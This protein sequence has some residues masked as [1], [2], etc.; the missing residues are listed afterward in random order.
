MNSIYFLVYLFPLLSFLVALLSAVFFPKMKEDTVSKKSIEYAALGFSFF[1]LLA[2]STQLFEVFNTG[3]PLSDSFLWTNTGTREINISIKI[4]SLTAFFQFSIS[5]IVFAVHIY[6]LAY[7]KKKKTFYYGILGLF[8]FAMQF[9]LAQ[10][11]LILFFVFWELMGLASFLLIDFDKTEK[12]SRA[13]TKAFLLNRIGDVGLLVAIALLFNYSLS[14]SEL[15]TTFVSI[16]YFTK[17][18]ISIGILLAALVKSGQFPFSTWLF[19]AMEAPTSI[20]ALLHAATMVAAGIYLLIRMEFVFEEVKI[21]AEILVWLALFSAVFSA[22]T[23]YFTTNLKQQLAAS[24]VSQLGFM[25]IAVGVGAWQAAVLHLFT[26]AF[27]KATLFLG[28]GFLIEK[29]GTKQM[30]EMGK[31]NYKKLPFFFLIYAFA[32]AALVGIPFTSG[33]L[34]KEWILKET[35]ENHFFI[36]IGLFVATFLT[37]FYGGRQLQPLFFNKEESNKSNGNNFSKK[38]LWYLPLVLLFGGSFWFVFSFHPLKPDESYWLKNLPKLFSNAPNQF[39]IWLP[40][41]A[42]FLTFLGL[43][44][45]F[46]KKLNQKL[47]KIEF[48]PKIKNYFLWQDNFFILCFWKPV[49]QIAT[50]TTQT[51]PPLT[52]Q[53]IVRFYVNIALILSLFDRKL[54]SAIDNFSK[55]IVILGHFF[56]WIDKYVVDFSTHFAVFIINLAA[57]QLKSLQNGKVQFYLL[58]VVSVLI[59][60]LI[61][62]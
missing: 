56:A 20:S 47:I 59:L 62:L 22:L 42:T 25:A 6:S 1:A 52:T 36:G 45:G 4:D 48:L 38:W 9:L 49:T 12:S 44:L 3:Q 31:D 28:A 26:H 19:D 29:N 15:K 61:F 41:L 58:I 32:L 24:T 2:T 57:K 53:K 10:D 21:I 55:V 43:T 18:I 39:K 37:A 35:V 13:S 30:S 27:F 40:I 54:D 60:A 23:A 33:F 17:V 5:L 46:S 7:I 16:P 8:V 14:I 11:N 51:K 34:S 50:L